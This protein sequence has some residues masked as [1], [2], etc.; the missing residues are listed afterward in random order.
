MTSRHFTTWFQWLTH[1][2]FRIW[3]FDHH[4]TLC[5]EAMRNFGLFIV[6]VKMGSWRWEWLKNFLYTIDIE[7]CS[8]ATF[9][10]SSSSNTQFYTFDTS[11]IRLG[12]T[13]QV[14][15]TELTKLRVWE[16]LCH[17][18]GKHSEWCVFTDGYMYIHMYIMLLKIYM[19]I[20]ALLYTVV[21]IK[22]RYPCRMSSFAQS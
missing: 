12:N 19:Y 1:I 14:L 22:I 18:R 11:C 10:I 13:N 7:F 15:K 5:E 17:S 21:A 9:A 20:N 3:L 2:I 6:R 8:P 4:K 16:I